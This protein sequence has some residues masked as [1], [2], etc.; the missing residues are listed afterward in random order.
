MGYLNMPK[1]I[2][3]YEA[4]DYSTVSTTTLITCYKRIAFALENPFK[5]KNEINRLHTYLSGIIN[6]DIIIRELQKRDVT[7]KIEFDSITHTSLKID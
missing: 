4:V 2:Q 5:G 6:L 1:A 3:Q 7:F